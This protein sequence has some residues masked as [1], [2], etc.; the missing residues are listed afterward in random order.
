MIEKLKYKE[1]TD[2][3]T[4]LTELAYTLVFQSSDSEIKKTDD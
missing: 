2:M 3:N 1:N 4:F